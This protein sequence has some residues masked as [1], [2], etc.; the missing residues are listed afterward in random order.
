MSSAAQL[1]T[2]HILQID[3]PEGGISPVS[4]PTPGF[5]HELLEETWGKDLE[6]ECELLLCLGL[7]GILN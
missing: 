7:P 5:S 6:T 3:A 2:N 1:V 4:F